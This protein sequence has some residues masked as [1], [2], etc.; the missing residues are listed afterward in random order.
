MTAIIL[1][2]PESLAVFC[3]EVWAEAK[4]I[5]YEVAGVGLGSAEFRFPSRAAAQ[6]AWELVKQ[7]VAEIGDNATVY[8]D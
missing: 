1:S 3:E 6:V 4:A 2:V 5:D 8:E 7:R